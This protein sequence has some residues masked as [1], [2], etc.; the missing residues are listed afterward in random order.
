MT[1]ITSPVPTQA[2][3][4]PACSGVPRREVREEIP[5]ETGRAV[6]QQVDEQQTTSVTTPTIMH[7]SPMTP[8]MTVPALVPGDELPQRLQFLFVCVTVAMS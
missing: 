1:S 7:S 8:K 3:R 2:D 4:M 6:D 5:G